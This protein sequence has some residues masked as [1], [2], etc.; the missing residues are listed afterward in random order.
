MT[1]AKKKIVSDMQLLKVG[2]LILQWKFMDH[3]YNRY[4]LANN[5]A[6]AF[7]EYVTSR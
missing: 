3:S 2:W 6:L 5:F 4:K 7:K 1:I